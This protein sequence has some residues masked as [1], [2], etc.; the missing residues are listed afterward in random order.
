MYT[1]L[2]Y[3]KNLNIII[4]IKSV[5]INKNTH[6][7]KEFYFFLILKNILSLRDSS[8]FIC[9][10]GGK[11]ACGTFCGEIGLITK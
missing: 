9:K 11:V 5:S 6:E 4:N 3:Y 1:Q 10:V 2:L 7:Q 8:S